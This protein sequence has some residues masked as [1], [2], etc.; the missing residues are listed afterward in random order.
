MKKIIL[1]II[2]SLILTSCFGEEM[3]PVAEKIPHKFTLHGKEIIDNYA[4]LRDKNWPNVT[5]KKILEYVK[6]ENKYSESF[7]SENQMLKDRLFKELKSRI[8]L[9][10]QTV[11]VKKDNY[12]YYSR[13]EL[14]K[15]Y[16]IYCRKEGSL[17]DKEE[18]YLDVNEL[19]KDKKFTKI[20]ALSPSPDHKLLAYSVDFDGNEQYIIY[21][22]DL[23]SGKLLKDQISSTIG[24]VYWHESGKGFFY[25]P[26]NENWRHDKVMYH[27]LGNDPMDVVLIMHDTDVLNQLSGSKSSSRKYFFIE[28]SGHDSSEIYY[29][30]MDD[31]E[32]KPK[33]LI[34]RKEKIFYDIDHAG[35]YFYVRT[36]DKG[37]NFRL[38]RIDV[39]KPS[40]DNMKDYLPHQENAYLDSFDVSKNY[41]VTNYK[42]DGLSY[43]TIYRTSDG[44]KKDVN[45]PDE[46]YTAS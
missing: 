17:E 8:K 24:Q 33:L 32:F 46:V 23:K 41:L 4:W 28:S 29:F 25:T 20:S 27:A 6:A 9:T 26:V 7:F 44:D 22:K 38:A 11:P 31:E 34:S 43:V 40:E 42:V 16:S 14:D 15:N 18:I 1:S 35:D 10:D 36:N 12:F 30:S 45:L 3:A 21:V 13:T 5:D 19:A 39:N 37:H 2:T